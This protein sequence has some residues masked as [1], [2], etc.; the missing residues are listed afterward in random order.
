MLALRVRRSL[1]GFTLEAELLVRPA[2]VTVLVGESGA[3][4]STLLALVAGIRTPDAGRITLD[5][6]VLF[7]DAQ[8]VNLPP[9]Q[10]PVGWVAQDYAL[11]P[12]LSV[13]EN[14]AFGLR[15]ERRS[16]DEVE[17]RVTPLL[18]RTGLI[19]L[20]RRRPHELSGGQ[21][22]RVA[23]ARALVLE[24]RALL[25]DE[26]L[27]ALDVRTRGAMRAELR[28]TLAALPCPTLYVTHQPSEALSFGDRIAVMEAGRI[29][30]EGT[31]DEF[32]RGPRTA[33]VAEFLGVNLFEGEIAGP[34]SGGLVEVRVGAHVV[35]APDPGRL[36]RVRLVVHPHDVVLDTQAPHGSARNVLKATV[37]ELV[38]EPPRGDLLRVRLTGPPPLTALITQAAAQALGLAPGREVWASFK[39]TGVEVLP[40]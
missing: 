29:T 12:H 39:A 20:A 9:E 4:K 36:G 13:R 2:Q 10:R 21:Q 5:D 18:A 3:G 35:A 26:P 34:A 25:L 16:G 28:R 7:D 31:R 33:Y 30:Q 32:V 6:R 17:R 38:P 11:F 27:A 15:A 24:P 8:G 1:A 37:E 40:D 23:L 22:Q 19:E 14:V